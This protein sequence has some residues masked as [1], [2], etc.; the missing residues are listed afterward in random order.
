MPVD[1]Q[2][3][4]EQIHQKVEQLGDQAQVRQELL[5]EALNLLKRYAHRQDD[6]RALVEQVSHVTQNLRCAR[7]TT[8]ALDSAFAGAP[9][10]DGWILLAADGSQITPDPHRAVEFG[11]INTGLFAF[12]TGA[13]PRE[14]VKSEILLFNEL[15]P[16]HV[17]LG[18]EMLALQRDLRERRLLLEQARQEQDA[19]NLP[20][21]TLTDGPL[22]LFRQPQGDEDLKKAFQAYL[23][24]LA[25]T[26]R[27]G[28]GVA[29]YVDRPR[30]D[31]VVALLELVKLRETQSLSAAGKERPLW[32]VRDIDLFAHMLP[33][34]ARSA[35]FEIHSLSAARF[36]QAD[37]ALTLCFFY[38]NV[39][40][41]EKPYL[42]RVELPRFVAQD[43]QQVALLQA[44]LLDQCRQMGARPYPYALS[45]AHEI[46]VVR[47]E[48]H[49]LLENMILMEIYR[50]GGEMQRES[51][52][53]SSKHTS[54]GG[55]RA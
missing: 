1:Y 50:R 26:R 9:A 35:I 11:V 52:K 33:P 5:D 42:V 36:S 16:N 13:I 54:A 53:L 37:E 40:T 18:E 32:G 55:K 19:E 47:Y 24:V 27:A 12:K 22:E 3:I 14:L 30:S 25:E 46:A 20:I 51:H 45:R 44:I 43:A 21:F 29:G 15:Y 17:P 48:E 28:I 6:L 41:Q 49:Q 4:R 39:G 38:L 31:Y 23:N 8:E 2:Q 10:P 34:G 7:P